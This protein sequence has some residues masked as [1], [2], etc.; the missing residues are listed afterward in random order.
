[1]A[2]DGGDGAAELQ[3]VIASSPV[4]QDEQQPDQQAAAPAPAT[5]NVGIFGEGFA[6]LH[7]TDGDP[8]LAALRQDEM[9]FGDDLARIECFG[10]CSLSS[11]LTE[12]YIP[13][14]GF[15]Y[16]ENHY[17][18]HGGDNPSIWALF[19]MLVCRC[20]GL[21]SSDRNAPSI[22]LEREVYTRLLAG[23]IS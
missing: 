22:S 13:P 20:I 8:D 21:S 10:F 16:M 3:G 11:L 18:Y 12:G 19:L 4:A 17:I 23:W 1:M 5:N 9:P 6:F 7:Q 2:D 15:D 14:E